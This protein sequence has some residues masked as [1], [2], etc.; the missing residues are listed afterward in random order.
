M[1]QN[2]EFEKHMRDA[3]G[4]TS[5]ELRV[6]QRIAEGI[7][8]ELREALRGSPVADDVD[9]LLLLCRLERPHQIALAGYIR[10][11]LLPELAVA[12][13]ASNQLEALLDE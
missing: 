11:G 3:F 5:Q 4:I 7:H 8:S 13:M 6:M 1:D 9:G 10:K 2:A 12:L